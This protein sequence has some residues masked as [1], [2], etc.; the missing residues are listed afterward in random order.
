MSDAS[1]KIEGTCDAKFAA[2]KDIF[3]EN[4]AEHDELGAAVAVYLDGKPVIDMWGG[5]RD[6]ARTR[7]WSEDTMAC[8]FSVSKAYVSV[9]GHMLAD[10][11]R[12]DLDKKVADYWPEFA[13]A[14]KEDVTVRQIFEH[15]TG[16]SYVDGELKPGDLYDWT[17]MTDALAKSARH[18]PF[19][20]QPT[21]LNLTYG[22]LLG[23]VIRRI[24][25]RTLGPFL[26]EEIAKPLGADFFFALSDAEIARCATIVPEAPPADAELPQP[27]DL[28]ALMKSMQGLADSDDRFN[29]EVWR[30]AEV[31][32]GSG[33]GT[34]RGVAKFY[35]C[36]ANGGA[37]ERTRLLK[38]ETRDRVIVQTGESVDAVFGQHNRFATGFLLND[39]PGAPMGPNPRAFGHPGAGGRTG[40]ADPDANLSFAYMPNLMYWGAGL[41]PRGVRLIEAVY[42]AL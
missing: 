23:E 37:L 33:H 20:A 16:L 4:F 38:K 15:R 17:T 31:G 32:A 27:A 10:R 22:Y 13:Q 25:G 14:G 3:A 40:F 34:A 1:P 29:L 24:D 6:A 5:F 21:Y 2:V 12:L 39:P 7:R 11:G 28:A 42:A 30:K 26:R 9:M 41:S 35:A 19:E 18:P 36:L 8:G